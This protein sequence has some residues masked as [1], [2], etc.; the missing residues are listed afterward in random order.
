MNERNIT[1]VPTMGI[2]Y[3]VHDVEYAALTA[4]VYTCKIMIELAL[5]LKPRELEELY[6]EYSDLVDQGKYMECLE[7]LDKMRKK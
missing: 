3:G 5:H 7:L 1:A 2:P 6:I 4:Q